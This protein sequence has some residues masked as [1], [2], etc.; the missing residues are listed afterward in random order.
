MFTIPNRDS[1]SITE[2][3]SIQGEGVVLI[4]HSYHII[5]SF[6]F[7]AESSNADVTY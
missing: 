5:Y 3:R 7:I 6:H 1:V 2:S 4:T